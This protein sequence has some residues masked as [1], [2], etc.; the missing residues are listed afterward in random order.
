MGHIS[1]M[2]SMGYT[3][4]IAGE[5]GSEYTMKLIL[6]KNP[7]NLPEFIVIFGNSRSAVSARLRERSAAPPWR[8]RPIDLTLSSPELVEGRIEGCSSLDK[9][10]GHAPSIR[11]ASTPTRDEGVLRARAAK[12]GKGVAARFARARRSPG[13]PFSI[14][15]SS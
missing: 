10:R 3:D 14:A 5:N 15:T 7:V 1:N 6:S 11:R 12:S 13:F 4:S 8:G 2:I 9:L